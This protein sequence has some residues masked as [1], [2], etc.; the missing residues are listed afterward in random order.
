MTLK[1]KILQYTVVFEPAEE[2]GYIVSV[3]SLPG[4]A[5]QGETVKEATEMIKDAIIGYLFS[6]KK[7]DES[8]PVEEEEK[9]P[10][11]STIEIPWPQKLIRQ[12]MSA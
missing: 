1:K 11:I 2:G 5:T 10:F 8:I 3:P 12:P 4:C 9:K 6:L 7:H